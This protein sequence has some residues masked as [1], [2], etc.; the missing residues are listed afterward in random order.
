MDLTTLAAQINQLDSQPPFDEWH[1]PFCGDID[2]LIKADGSWHYMN[3]PIG[4]E[5]L[6]QLFAR[7]LIKEDEQY[8][9]KTP[10]E[11]VRI[12]VQDTPFIITQW[13]QHSTDQGTAIEVISNVGH[14]VLLS[15]QH[16]LMLDSGAGADADTDATANTDVDTD[17]KT[18]A[19]NSSGSEHGLP[20]V[21]L[22]RGLT[23]RVHRNV[24][25]QWVELGYSKWINNQEHLVI[26]STGQEFSLGTL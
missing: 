12:Q 2:M 11:K 4:R 1:P 21:V 10:G 15:P 14:S 7:V 26:A 19:Q 3:S 23:A 13:Q 20:Y 6:V 16:P 18:G 22:H 25:Y 9:L 24:F 5:R 17:A 8:F